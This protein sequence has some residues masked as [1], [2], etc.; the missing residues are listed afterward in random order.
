[1]VLRRHFVVRMI[2]VGGQVV[3]LF[4]V[5]SMLGAIVNDGV[6]TCSFWICICARRTVVRLIGGQSML[7]RSELRS[8][9]IRRYRTCSGELGKVGNARMFAMDIADSSCIAGERESYMFNV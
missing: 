5:I 1:M 3:K 2:G 8:T 9:L 7:I 4:D 6:G